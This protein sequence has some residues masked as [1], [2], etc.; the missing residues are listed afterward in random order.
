MDFLF[1]GAVKNI[2][3]R[4]SQL[5]TSVEE[6]KCRIECVFDHL[7]SIFNKKILHILLLCFDVVSFTIYTFPYVTR[8]NLIILYLNNYIKIIFCFIQQKMLLN[9][10]CYNGII[11]K[12]IS[13]LI[14]SLISFSKRLGPSQINL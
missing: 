3:Y 6:L 8:I 9:F 13:R 4:S 5:F 1:W 11:N 2:I 10:L 12:V 7:H 14:E